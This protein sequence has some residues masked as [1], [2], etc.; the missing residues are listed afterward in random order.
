[1]LWMPR[2]NMGIL[3][4]VMCSIDMVLGTFYNLTGFTDNTS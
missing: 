4:V 1:M 3:F 2:F